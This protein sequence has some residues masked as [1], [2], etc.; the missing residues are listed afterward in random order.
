MFSPIYKVMTALLKTV[1]L[2][3]TNVCRLV[4]VFGQALRGPYRFFTHNKPIRYTDQYHIT[5]G[6]MAFPPF[7]YI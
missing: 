3:K 7:F 5:W 4:V 6:S 1:R 2:A